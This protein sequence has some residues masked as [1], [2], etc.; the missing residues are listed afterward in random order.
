MIS[1][2]HFNISSI[3]G[4]LSLASEMEIRVQ[5]GQGLGLNPACEGRFL[6]QAPNSENWPMDTEQ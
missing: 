2:S 3:V 4:I 5:G 6:Q 1:F